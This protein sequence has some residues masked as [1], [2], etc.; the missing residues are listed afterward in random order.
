MAEALSA[1]TNARASGR[2]STVES[3]VIAIPAGTTLR[4]PRTGRAR[5]GVSSSCDSDQHPR[6]VTTRKRPGEGTVSA[7]LLPIP[8]ARRRVSEAPRS[9]GRAPGPVSASGSLV[10]GPFLGAG[11]RDVRLGVVS[12]Y[13]REIARSSPRTFRLLRSKKLWVKRTRSPNPLAI[14]EQPWRCGENPALT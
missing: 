7:C 5:R 4:Q 11:N 14:S 13:S 10:R 1:S 2:I 3:P 6:K 12:R 9:P 8:A